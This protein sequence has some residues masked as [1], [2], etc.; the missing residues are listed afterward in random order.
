MRKIGILGGTFDPIHK[1]HI[2]IAKEAMKQFDLCEVRFLTGGIPPHKRER[3]IT[4]ADI[5]HK[6]C[7]LATDGTEEFVADNFELS[8]TDYTYSVKILSELKELHPDWD[9]HFIIGEDSLRD[10]H[11]WYNPEKIAE[12]CTLLVY[13]RDSKSNIDDLVVKRCE[14]YNATISIIRAERMNISSTQIRKMVK[15][16][17]DISEF[18]PERVAEYINEKGLYKNE[19]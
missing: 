11:S 14:E 7:E 15:L 1:G 17:E 13:P 4:A 12:L 2:N 10:F 5:R 18:V 16:G 3:N 9:I 6:M 8:K 19:N